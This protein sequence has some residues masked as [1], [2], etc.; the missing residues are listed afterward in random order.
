MSQG[1]IEL[2][3]VLLTGPKGVGKTLFVERF[4]Q[5]TS[6]PVFG[7]NLGLLNQ[8]YQ[9]E[10]ETKVKECFREA[11]SET[12]SIMFIDEIDRATKE[13][14]SGLVQCLLQ[15]FSSILPT[16]QL[17]IVAT[18]SSD[19]ESVLKSH[20]RLDFEI[21]FDSPSPVGRLEILKIY[22]SHLPNNI[23]EQELQ[24]LAN[25][26]AGFVGADFS[27]AVRASYIRASSREEGVIGKDDLEQA[28][29]KTRPSSI[30][31]L[32]AKVPEVRWDEIGGNEEVI[33]ML[34]EV[35]EMPLKHAE[36]FEHMG[37]K[38]P[39][40][41]MLHGPPGC[42]KTLCAKALATESRL[43]FISVKGPELFSKYVGDTEKAIREIF[44]R[45]RISSPCI[46]FFDEIDAMGSARGEGDTSVSDRALC[47]LL[48][49]MDGTEETEGV[50]IIGATN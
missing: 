45:A 32:I 24:K 47:Q 6:Y 40:G 14:N 22:L 36:A 16:D 7:I 44:K 25:A 50:I 34:R 27:A 48:T 46:I 3:G 21:P 12:P 42:S 41:V 8:K 20:G 15:I 5:Q 2:N 31:D 19:I 26:T 18:A 4:S 39:R 37:F 9:G 17:F 33:K 35:V 38:P 1:K 49:E 13:E 28:I 43:N 10:A 29:L 11:M 23:E 30:S